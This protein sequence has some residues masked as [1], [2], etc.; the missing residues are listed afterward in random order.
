[1][2]LL[3]RGPHFWRHCST[4]SIFFSTHHLAQVCHLETSRFH[5]GQLPWPG[6]TVQQMPLLSV[7]WTPS[8][9][10]SHSGIFSRYL[11]TRWILWRGSSKSVSTPWKLQNSPLSCI[12]FKLRKYWK[13]KTA[14]SSL[15][16]HMI[17]NGK[18][19]M[20]TTLRC[21]ILIYTCQT[22]LHSQ[23]SRRERNGTQT[24]S[25]LIKFF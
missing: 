20:G 7:G 12:K 9:L 15:N 14:R 17:R 25:G 13:I 1:M 6:S 23:I 4:I 11:K 24:G 18:V 16:T 19:E 5:L 2:L 8:I 10:F 21:D 22:Y 3:V